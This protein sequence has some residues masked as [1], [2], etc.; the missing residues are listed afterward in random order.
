MPS[1]PLER[2]RRLCLA[3]PEAHEKIAW[4]EPTFRVKD[5]LFAMFAAAGNHHGAGRVAVWVKAKAENQSLMVGA[6]PTR[7]FV[8]PYVGPSGWIGVWLDRG[9]DW[10]GLG[11]LLED[12]YRLTAPRRLLA[13]L[14]GVG[15]PAPD[16]GTSKSPG[17]AAEK[18]ASTPKRT[19]TAKRTPKAKRTSTAKGTSSSK[20]TTKATR[21]VARKASAASKKTP[22]E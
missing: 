11:A 4:G 6:E 2:L 10:N 8:P 18:R 22:R 14:G 5:K 17:R 19:S 21:S 20:R 13:Q 3:L 12:A 7:F 9:T 15:V 1:D 16:E